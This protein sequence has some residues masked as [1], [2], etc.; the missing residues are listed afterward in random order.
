[1]DGCNTVV[2]CHSFNICYSVSRL[3]WMLGIHSILI[4]DCLS[5]TTQNISEHDA[6]TYCNCWHVTKLIFKTSDPGQFSPNWFQKLGI[7][8]NFMISSLAK[9]EQSCEAYKHK[10]NTSGHYFIDVDGS[11]PIK[12]QLIYCNMTGTACAIRPRSWPVPCH[13]LNCVTDTIFSFCR[14][15]R[16]GPGWWSST[17]TQN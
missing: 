6:S 2:A 1:M 9:Y 5:L 13:C 14:H 10:G 11:G 4:L 7:L 17:I 16:T 15:Q 3:W 8:I 12:P